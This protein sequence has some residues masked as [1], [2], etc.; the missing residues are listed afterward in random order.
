[1]HLFT[2]TIIYLLVGYSS[3]AVLSTRPQAA[4]MVSRVSGAMM[5]L[6]AGMLLYGQM[7]AQ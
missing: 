1:M 4:R 5:I 2:C 7:V 3:R 6:I